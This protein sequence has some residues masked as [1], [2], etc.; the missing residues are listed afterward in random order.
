MAAATAFCSNFNA[1]I[2]SLN[3]S[4]GNQGIVSIPLTGE[5][6]ELQILESND[7]KLLAYGKDVPGHGN[8]I[9]KLNM[10]GSFDTSFGNAGTLT[11]PNYPGNFNVVFQ[12]SDKILVTFQKSTNIS[13]LQLSVLRYN[14]NGTP[15]TSFAT[16][17]EFT[18]STD[19]IDGFVNNT[20]VLSDNSILIANG[21]KL[22]KLTSNGAIDSSYGN[23]GSVDYLNNGSIQNSNS[24]LFIFHNDKINKTSLNGINNATF[25]T[26]GT[27]TYPEA[28]YFFSKQNTDG[29]IYSLDLDNSKFYNVSSAGILSNT[30]SLTNDSN[31]LE[32]YSSFASA[33]NKIFFVGTTSADAPFIVSYNNS[34]NP[35]SLNSQISYKETAIPT[36]NY[37]SLLAKNN[38]LYV[39][40]DRKDTSTNQWYYVVAKYNI[41][42]ATLA[43]MESTAEHSISFES[44]A[45]SNLNFSTT[46]KVDKIEI[47]SADGKLIKRVNKNNSD[48]SD[49]AK[50]VYIIKTEL[51]NGKVITKKVLKN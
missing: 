48:V 17:G 38:T 14:A 11:L 4:F 41:S 40:G 27:F 5:A 12:G 1:Q 22:I 16:N 9:Y 3:T 51:L 24:D 19:A 23:N 39:A 20:A 8:K 15:D 35:V 28:G 6:N 49:L 7:G 13:P 37:T 50:G 47:Y 46:E 10:D 26:N 25:G 21:S 18:A 29:T 36:G 34:G 31:T 33:G 42:D 2:I 43:T 30:I 32:Y 45:K 44:P